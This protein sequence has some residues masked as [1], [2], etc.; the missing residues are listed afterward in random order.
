MSYSSST[1]PVD[2]G[3]G[4]EE[5]PVARFQ[6]VITAIL[7][8]I[9][10][11]LISIGIISAMDPVWLKELNRSGIQTEASFYKDFGDR[12]MHRNEYGKAI[13]Q[14]IIALCLKPDYA[15]VIVNLAVAYI[16]TYSFEAA[17]D[18]LKESLALVGT[19]TGVIY[20]NLGL[21]Y[22]RLGRNTDA[23]A[24]YKQALGSE[25]SQ[26]MVYRKLARLYV[27]SGRI[28]DALA[29]LKETLRIQTDPA[30]SYRDMLYH[31]FHVYDDAEHGPHIEKLMVRENWEQALSRR[32]DL[33]IIRGMNQQDPEIAVTHN[34]L[35]NVYTQ[36]GNFTLAAE[37]YN[38]A[39]N[40]QNRSLS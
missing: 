30:S 8:G 4:T 35:G 27:A 2:S 14:Y 31:S 24:S 7:I 15:D 22:E 23:I 38:E 12:Y 10:C 5:R 21:L 26:W 34:E 19:Q 28:D 33:E 3:S 25:M 32:F 16:Y 36:L 17:E 29:A 1:T 20:Y 13:E 39:Q 40:I 9:W 37:H 11:M 6:T 18:L